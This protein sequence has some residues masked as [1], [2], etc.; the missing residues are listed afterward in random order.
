MLANNL[1]Y[2]T[3]AKGAEEFLTEEN[4]AFFAAAYSGDALDK[5]WWW[6]IQDTWFVE[7]RNIYQDRFLSA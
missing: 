5:L 4:K 1:G 6:P 7:K 2:N 3:T